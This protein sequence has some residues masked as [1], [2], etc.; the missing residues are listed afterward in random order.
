[1]LD[2]TAARQGCETK[3]RWWP[4]CSLSQSEKIVDTIRKNGGKVTFVVYPDEGHGFARPENQLDF[5]S[6]NLDM[7]WLNA[8]CG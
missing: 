5:G 3:L 8:F 4:I 7:L 1:M 2:I 6:S